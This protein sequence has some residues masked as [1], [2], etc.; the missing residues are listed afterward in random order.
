M[1]VASR[2]ATRSCDMLDRN[3]TAKETAGNY[4]APR[5]VVH[6]LPKTEVPMRIACRVECVIGGEAQ[7]VQSQNRTESQDAQRDAP[8]NESAR[9]LATL[10]QAAPQA[11]SK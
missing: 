8:T 2:K 10:R 6:D 4:D 11:G 9:E 7:P 1:C 5:N 3:R